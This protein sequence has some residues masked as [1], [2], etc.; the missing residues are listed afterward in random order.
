MSTV[1]VLLT[2]VPSAEAAETLVNTLVAERLIACGNITVPVASI[3][4]WQGKIERAQEVVV[5]IKT[6]QDAVARVTERVAELHPYEVPEVLS[7][8][9]DSGYAPYLDWVRESVV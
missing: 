4:R 7:L 5:I 2:T 1:R 8:A 9:V 6:T 3:Y